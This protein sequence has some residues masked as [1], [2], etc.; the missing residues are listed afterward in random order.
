[1]DCDTCHDL[2]CSHECHSEEIYKEIEEGIKEGESL[3]VEIK[4]DLETY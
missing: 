2:L 4:K 3:I 1:M